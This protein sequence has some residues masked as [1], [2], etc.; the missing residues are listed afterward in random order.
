MVRIRHQRGS[1]GRAAA[2]RGSA[3]GVI[4]MLTL[5]LAGCGTGGGGAYVPPGNVVSIIGRITDATNGVAISGATVSASSGSSVLGT[6]TTNAAGDYMLSSLSVP[7]SPITWAVS[8]PTFRS[9]STSVNVSG[10]GGYTVSY[11]MARQV[12]SV[13]GLVGAVPTSAT[14]RGPPGPAVGLVSRLGAIP[15]YALDR[16]VVKFKPNL[17]ADETQTL[18]R[19]AGGRV[20]KTISHLG[21]QVIKLEPGATASSAISRYRA[22]GLVEYVEQDVYAHITATPNDQ[23][24]FAQWHYSSIDLPSAWDTTTGSASVIVAVLDSGIRSHPDLDGITVQGR[25]TFDNDND[26][27]DPGCSTDP[28][29]FSH[30]M[31][32]SGTVA[33]LTNN[34]IGVA[35]VNWG[36]VAGTKIM[37]IRVTGEVPG[38]GCGVGFFSDIAEGIAYAA[39]HGAKVINMSLGGSVNSSTL[40]NAVNDAFSRGVTLVAA[41]GNDNGPVL[42]PAA[43]SNVIAVAATAC[44]NTKASY[45]NFGPQ[46]DVAAPGGDAGVICDGDSNSGYVW[47]TSWSPATGNVYPG[48][49]GTSMAAPHVTGIVALMISR[50]ITGPSNI[51]N[52]LQTT[53]THQGA[54]VGRNDFFGYGL[55]NAAAAVGG[56]TVATRL[57]AFSGDIIGSV[58]AIRSDI[59]EVLSNG[60]FLITNAHAGTRTIFA[61]QDFN[62][63]GILDS[64]D[65][66]GQTPGVVITDNVTASGVAVTV[67]RYSGSSVT[68]QSV[69]AVVRK[70]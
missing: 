10:G 48:F 67:Q 35:G 22:S 55:V 40:E 56:G 16:I 2:V 44:D 66:F 13:S 30:G 32:V 37:P 11:A 18:H 17:R 61:W 36:G 51:Q 26:P 50:G 14:R 65:Y 9:F 42:F 12:G 60:S 39:D 29:N 3:F 70:R 49:N 6:T 25:D 53:A 5:V 31:H 63:N 46:I 23:F 59:V 68:I 8:A 43:Y 54:T 7:S 4:V 57:R 21:A 28:S 47:S 62:G 20:L 34:T 69:L 58:L 1:Q 24:Y 45:S 64:G 19:Q 38:V 33:A 15:T 41:A 27:T 52:V